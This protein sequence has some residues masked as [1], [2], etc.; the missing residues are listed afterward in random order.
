MTPLSGG[1]CVLFEFSHSNHI[2]H[3]NSDNDDDDHRHDHDEL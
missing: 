2:S 3:I 1:S